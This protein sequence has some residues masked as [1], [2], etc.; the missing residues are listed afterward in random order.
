MHTTGGMSQQS[1]RQ[2]RPLSRAEKPSF[3]LFRLDFFKNAA[4]RP[5]IYSHYDENTQN[6]IS[7]ILVHNESSDSYVPRMFETERQ[8]SKNTT[9][10]P[11]SCERRGGAVESSNYYKPL[12]LLF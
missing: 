1:Q 7:R 3:A 6:L 4:S 8:H 5:S 10:T 9:Y 12:R 2:K 11:V